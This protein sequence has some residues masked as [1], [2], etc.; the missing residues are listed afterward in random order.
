MVTT[1]EKG[2][3]SSEDLTQQFC[4]E[5]YAQEKCKHSCETCVLGNIFHNNENL[6]NSSNAH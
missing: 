5:V 3:S 4:S 1:L 2:L 6:G